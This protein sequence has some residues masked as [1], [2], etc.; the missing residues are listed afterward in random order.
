[1][2]SRAADERFATI[3]ET[4]TNRIRGKV[5]RGAA[6]PQRDLREITGIEREHRPSMVGGNQLG[7]IS[8]NPPIHGAVAEHPVA[9]PIK[10]PAFKVVELAS[11][12]VPSRA[13]VTASIGGLTSASKR[14]SAAAING[15]GAK[16]RP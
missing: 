13:A 10:A 9:R 2:G 4:P 12:F 15:T 3:G 14:T 5:K 1:V 11:R 8:R 6:A 7:L 16:Y